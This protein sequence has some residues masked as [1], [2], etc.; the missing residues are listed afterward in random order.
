MG[1]PGS[2]MIPKGVGAPPPPGMDHRRG[3]LMCIKVRMLDDSVGVFHLGHK[4]L[5]QALFDEVCRHLNLLECDY[6][7]LEFTDC[8]GNRCWLDKDKP[9]LR[10]ITT[11]HSDARFYFIVKFY[12]PNPAD[13]VEEYTRY[14][15]ALQ[16]KRDL[17]MGELL[18][19]ENTA[20]LLA[21]YIVQS[22]CGDFAAED[23]P[24][25][26]YLSSARF[27][28]N[29]NTEFQRKVMENHM[30]LIYEN[31]SGMSPGESDLTLLET[32]RRCD[33][34]GVKL[35]AAKDV[36]GTEVN[37]TIAHMGIRV[38]HQFQCVSTFSWAK[39]RKLSFKRRKLLI[40][41][42]PENYQYYK[43][44]IE[45]LFETRNE[46]KN[47]WKKCVEHHTFFRCI[48]VLPV[49]KTREGRFFSKGSAFRYQGRTQKQ[50]I[51][52]T[53]EHRKRREPFTRPIKS[54]LSS[55]SNGRF[56]RPAFFDMTHPAYA[57]VSERS[58][59]L[60]GSG[61]LPSR[62]APV[63]C[64]NGERSMNRGSCVSN[65][66][67]SRG[68][69]QQL[70]TTGT[71]SYFPGE[72]TLK[73]YST[74]IGT[75]NHRHRNSQN[76]PSNSSAAAVNSERM[77][78]SDMESN[79][80]CSLAG[81]S[82]TNSR[83]RQQQHSEFKPLKQTTVKSVKAGAVAVTS[84]T[85][86]IANASDNDAI[87]SVSLPNVLGDDV[88]IV[89]REFE[90]KCECPPKSASGDNFLELHQPPRDYDNISEG[91]YKLSDN[92]LRSAHSDIQAVPVNP[93]YA[94]TF[95]AKRVGNV[96]VKKVVSNTR[97]TPNTTDDEDPH[98]ER[99]LGSGE[100][101]T[102]AGRNQQ[103]ISGQVYR[104]ESSKSNQVEID[105][106]D[107]QRR[108]YAE[109]KH[110]SSAPASYAEYPL[111]QKL[112][113]IEIDGPN[114][115]LDEHRKLGGRKEINRVSKVHG[116]TPPQIPV[117]APITKIE[118]DCWHITNE[119][120]PSVSRSK[121][122]QPKHSKI[123][124][125]S[126][127]T[128]LQKP[129]IIPDEDDLSTSENI[130]SNISFIH[131]SD[132]GQSYMTIAQP[133]QAPK[134]YGAIGP[135]SGKVITKDNLVIT[136]E[137]YRERKPKP[138]VPPK[139][140]NFVCTSE[141]GLIEST[142]VSRVPEI[143]PNHPVVNLQKETYPSCT[144]SSGTRE[145]NRPTLISVQSEDYPEIQKCHL[146]NSDIPYVLTM[147]NISTEAEGSF[148]TFKDISTK[149]T[150]SE[151]LANT[152]ESG[153]QHRSLSGSR[154]PDSLRR[155]KSLD[156][157][158]KKR[159]PSPG[160]FSSQDHSL[161]PSTPE[162]G[163]VLEYLLRRRNVEKSAIAKRGRRG[164]P[165]RQTQPVRFN[166]PSNEKTERQ[167]IGAISQPN[168]NDNDDEVKYVMENVERMTKDLKENE[169]IYT[170]LNVNSDFKREMERSSETQKEKKEQSGSN[171]I[172]TII[173]N[174]FTDSANTDDFPPPPPPPPPPPSLPIVLK[175]SVPSEPITE[176]CLQ[177]SVETLP[178]A[179]E[180]TSSRASCASKDET[181]D[182]K[183]SSATSS[184]LRTPTGVLWTDF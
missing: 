164:D 52:Y 19:N 93:V 95:T 146:F 37:L 144:T 40:K 166:I 148:S 133:Q 88:Q 99:R 18:C 119:P 112:I 75:R 175:Q 16:I 56:S 153:S 116:T 33:Y 26:S 168:L 174:E 86:N 129:K 105:D 60:I 55:S 38:F 101:K 138:V 151:V 167:Q 90:L 62:N 111:H 115:N 4:A 2:G 48:E 165:R 39:I 58:V 162:S 145:L 128:I 80:L 110:S 173:G 17:A 127:G 84:K 30:K 20:A 109:R 118:S 24:D 21:S 130:Y 117:R 71:M 182:N 82:I 81:G 107:S 108:F 176:A 132:S 49:K 68:T 160:N 36:E 3:K 180:S 32:A 5:G 126:K 11:T 28:P 140:K 154:S 157:V 23:Y 122:L 63:Y 141:A 106:A 161:S 1:G 27:I 131:A 34:Y 59:N 114:V 44:T 150:V 91:S 92:E 177:E 83:Y 142:S 31:F 51:D 69:S 97:S 137:G 7:G 54:G 184:T 171:E 9:I 104:Q 143:K 43:E 41:L 94:T 8:Y 53:R 64:M 136:P 96:I 35:H 85:N 155:R 10:Q 183:I 50:L 181:V 67:H 103:N 172:T 170:N 87:T 61:T 124:Y 134:T 6:F 163:D 149:S 120:Q 79:D 123:V 14:L 42:H 158:P 113:P 73:N 74:T 102:E 57:T 22:D 15:F 121:E 159:L 98:S 65:Q 70:M 125:T 72:I 77:C 45:F 179:D 29:Q 66:S 13:L 100:R 147:R 156:L 25:D 139:P 78:L 89:C 12:T 169:R 46:C 178:Y 152:V 135:L 76:Y 47:F